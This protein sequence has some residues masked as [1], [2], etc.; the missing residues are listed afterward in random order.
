MDSSQAVR[1]LLNPRVSNA[2]TVVRSQQLETSAAE[3]RVLLSE[4]QREVY[5]ISLALLPPACCPPVHVPFPCTQVGQ[6]QIWPFRQV[7]LTDERLAAAERAAAESSA[8]ASLAAASEACACDRAIEAER[9]LAAL[10]KEREEESPSGE[11][12]RLQAA[13]HALQ[14]ELEQEVRPSDIDSLS[15][16][17][18]LSLILLPFH[19]RSPLP[20]FCL[21]LPSPSIPYACPLPAPFRA[22]PPDLFHLP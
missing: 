3:L 17:P 20:R 12:A 15:V 5:H 13:V 1:K 2:I 18:A 10:R 11:V 14:L 21:P 6:N 7:L 22:P 8:A 16:V 9:Q 19:L 4:A